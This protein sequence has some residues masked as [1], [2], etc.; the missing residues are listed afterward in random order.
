MYCKDLFL[1]RPEKKGFVKNLHSHG[2]SDEQLKGL[3]RASKSEKSI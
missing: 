3:D 2:R 1:R